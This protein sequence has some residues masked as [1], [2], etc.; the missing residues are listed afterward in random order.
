MKKVIL[1]ESDLIR[2]IERI[3]NEGK[4][5]LKKAYIIVVTPIKQ[6]GK[7]IM[8]KM[9]WGKYKDGSTIL[10]PYGE[11]SHYNSSPKLYFNPIDAEKDAKLLRRSFPKT[12]VSI[13]LLK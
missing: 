8:G 10:I 3:V 2:I 4:D 13:E 6:P 12:D 1:R 7:P 5:D 11:F 9:V